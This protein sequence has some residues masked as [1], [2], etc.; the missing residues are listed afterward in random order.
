MVDMHIANTLKTA[1]AYA[2]FGAV[3]VTATVPPAHAQPKFD[4]K[5]AKYLADRAAGELGALRDGFAIT[6]VPALAETGEFPDGADFAPF[7]ARRTGAVEREL[8]PMP[9]TDVRIVYAG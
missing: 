2:L 3:A 1:V 6:D 5:I 7:D 4:R 9:R 8:P